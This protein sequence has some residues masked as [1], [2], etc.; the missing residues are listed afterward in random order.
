MTRK[1][2]ETES[3]F[4]PSFWHGFGEELHG[5]LP[6]LSDILITSCHLQNMRRFGGV[7]IFLRLGGLGVCVVWAFC[8]SFGGGDSFGV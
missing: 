5:F 2:S 8:G 6:E 3:L 1:L 4:G 7:A